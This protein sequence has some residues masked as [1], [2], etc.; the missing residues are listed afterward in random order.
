MHDT[1]EDIKILKA[2]SEIKNNLNNLEYLNITEE[3]I[4][5]LKELCDSYNNLSLENIK[6]IEINLQKI[7][8]IILDNK[9]LPI[10]Y[11]NKLLNILDNLKKII[12]RLT[13]N[14]IIN[15]I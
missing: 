4:I 8:Q 3:Y 11:K 10:E 15:Y 12:I 14:T 7:Y 1:H 6:N 5:Y 9:D 2:F 13:V